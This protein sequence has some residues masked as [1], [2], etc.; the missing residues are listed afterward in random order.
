ML[1]R[2]A[3]VFLI[4]VVATFGLLSLAAAY[5]ADAPAQTAPSPAAP[6]A[7]P[8]SPIHWPGPQADGNTLLFNQWSIHPAGRQVQLG[9]FPVNVALHPS[10]NWAA[11]LHC[12]YR[13]PEIV[14][15]DLKHQEVASREPLAQSFYGIT[16]DPAGKRLFASG[17]EFEVVHEFSFDDG[18]LSHHR[19]LR[20]ADP[21]EKQIPAGVACSADGR[22]LWVACAWGS[23]LARVSLDGADKKKKADRLQFAENSYPYAVVPSHD[24]RRLYVSLWGHSA[25][26]V[27]DPAAW[28]IVANWRTGDTNWPVVMTD[29]ESSGSHPTE[30][31]ISPDDKLLYVACANLNSV[32][33]FDTSTGEPR[34]QIS[35]SLYPNVPN[36]SAP[37]SVALSADGKVLLVANSNNNN[38]AMFDVSQ[39]GKSRS[40]GFIPTGWYPTS[41]RFAP[42]MP[43]Q[44]KSGDDDDDK[45]SPPE[46][47]EVG[48]KIY[49]VNGKGLGSRPNPKG[50]VP[51]ELRSR[52]VRLA[53][54]YVGQLFPGTLA[55]IE[56]PSPRQMAEYSQQSRAC[57]PLKADASP[58]NLQL[59]ANNP[60]PSKVGDPSPI[61][62][63]I[64]VIRE[65]RTYDQVM[66]DVREGNGDPRLCLFGRQVTPNAHALVKQFVLLDNFYANAEVSAQGHEWS[67]AAYCSDF[68]EKVWPLHYR[69]EALDKIEYPGEGQHAIAFPA[70]GYI[71]D[72]CKEAGVTYRSYGEFVQLGPHHTEPGHTNVKTLVG[73]F[74]KYFH[75]FDLDYPDAKRIDEFLREFNW[76]LKS[77]SLPRF[78]VMRLPSDHTHGVVPGAPTPTAMVAENDAALGRLVDAVSHSKIWKDT[79]IFVV[80]DDAQNGSDHVDAHR[81]VALVISPYCRRGVVDSTLYSTTSML[82]TMELILGLQPMS[83]FDAAAAPMYGSFQ[84]KPDFEP[85]SRLPAEVRTTDINKPDA[86]GA[87]GS[88]KL[89]FS[90]EDA[91]DEQTLNQEIWH[92]VRGPDVPMP[93]PV[94]AAFVRTRPVVVDDDD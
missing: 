74:D 72:R 37:A 44:A 92:S 46:T 80:E 50:P 73:H 57:A 10:G 41:V 39:P 38:V 31:V 1:K 24:G 26:A 68:V 84:A 13:R 52:E 54:Q 19:E 88:M 18:K 79:A 20:I 36:G 43:R 11:V 64:Y 2:Y 66:G 30:M 58:T 67:T 45:K 90:R 12:G 25:V 8:R 60:V 6:Q 87:A 76:Y 81:T 42:A 61:K 85:Y 65:N 49:I 34:E 23:T 47:A 91:A 62:H 16:F 33:V 17:A 3:K 71:W 69:R 32:I 59:A 4:L 40:L 21:K 14:I 75:T 5:A 56:P 53:E 83:Q 15:V 89:D 27:V 93:P 29:G 7:S 94:H 77:D 82:R 35:T 22:T 51:T 70:V 28:K 48:Q 78:I 63:V 86:W 55:T 9:F